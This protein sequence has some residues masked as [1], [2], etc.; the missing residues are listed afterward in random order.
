MHF[1]P[2]EVLLALDVEFKPQLSAKEVADA[3]NRVEAAIRAQH[4]EIKHIFIE[5]KALA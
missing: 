3:I 5:A 2:H 1:G 4:P